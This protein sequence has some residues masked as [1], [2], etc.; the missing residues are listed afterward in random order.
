[1]PR[2]HLRHTP[3]TPVSRRSRW[4]RRLVRK[5][6]AG[7]ALTGAAVA[8]ILTLRPPSP[9]MTEVLVA[10]HDLD[11]GTTLSAADLRAT[12][13]PSQWVYPGSVTTKSELHGRVLTGPLAAGEPVTLARLVPRSAADGLALGQVAVHLLA[14]D[15]AALRL[16]TSGTRVT[17]YPATGGEAWAH[18]ALVLA[19]DPAPDDTL[20][21]GADSSPRGLTVALTQRD[22]DRIH[23]GQRPDGQPPAVLVVLA[24]AG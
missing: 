17:V 3:A 16:V 24:S 10:T 9:S 22:A 13:V 15:P 20:G 23:Q 8:V 14:A 2:L 11:G 5:V 19:V 7:L 12:R 21:L 18:A 1:M 4:R 6:L